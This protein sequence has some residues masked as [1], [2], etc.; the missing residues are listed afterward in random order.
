MIKFKKLKR[1]VSTVYIHCSAS[2]RPE[3]DNVAT[4]KQW[5]LER[6]FSDTGYHFFI[7]GIGMLENGRPLGKIPAAQK[8]HNTGSIAIC[9]HGLTIEKF[10]AAQFKTLLELC[11][12]IND[13][14]GGAVTFH[15]HC[16]VNKKKTCPVFDYRRVLGLDAAGHMVNRADPTAPA[17]Q[18]IVPASSAKTKHHKPLSKSKTLWSTITQNLSLAGVGGFVTQADGLSGGT[19]IAL[20]AVLVVVAGLAVFIG[21]ERIKKFKR[22]E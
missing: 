8:G 1:K 18:T 14:Y 12:A 7:R 13:A 16:E 3:H 15:G 9:L 11:Q 4:I 22:G 10:T 17:G 21:W 2:D 20:F 6:G 19:K 5:H